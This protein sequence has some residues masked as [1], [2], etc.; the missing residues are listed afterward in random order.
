MFKSL[1]ELPSLHHCHNDS[2]RKSE[3]V[4]SEPNMN[5]SQWQSFVKRQNAFE[6]G[7]STS[8]WVS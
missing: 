4:L 2:E 8:F 5:D 1:P 3:N 7:S 6:G